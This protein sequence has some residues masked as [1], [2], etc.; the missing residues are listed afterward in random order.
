MG[1][2]WLLWA[3]VSVPEPITEARME[4]GDWPEPHDMTAEGQSLWPQSPGITAQ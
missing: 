1:S 2:D 4:V 3:I